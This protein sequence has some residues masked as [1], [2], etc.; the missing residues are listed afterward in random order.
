MCV[1]NYAC[2][3]CYSCCHL[4]MDWVYKTICI[5]FVLYCTKEVRRVKAMKNNV[6]LSIFEH[7]FIFMNHRTFVVATHILRYPWAKITEKS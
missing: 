4:Y 2:I 3:P 1:V 6:K 7:F 5:V